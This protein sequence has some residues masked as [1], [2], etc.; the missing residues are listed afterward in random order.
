M[1][2]RD[3]EFTKIFPKSSLSHFFLLPMAG[4]A[5]SDVA[6]R[7]SAR[8]IHNALMLRAIDAYKKEMKKPAKSRHGYRRICTDFENIFFT[9]TGNQIKLCHMTLKRLVDGGMT[10]ERANANRAWLTD[11]EV[12]IVTR[13][14]WNQNP[15]PGVG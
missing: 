3:Q 15:G 14:F 7:I 5:K 1:S 4:R 2:Q 9:E 12:D 10:R 13:G 6:K 11:A 8:A